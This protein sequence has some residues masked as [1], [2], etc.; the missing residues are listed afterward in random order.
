MIV[1]HTLFIRHIAYVLLYQTII[2]KHTSLNTKLY[3]TLYTCIL[4]LQDYT[5]DY[6]YIKHA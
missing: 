6:T 1:K 5:Q 3:R 4:L 2:V